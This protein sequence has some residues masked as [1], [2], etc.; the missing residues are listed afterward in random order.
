MR[1]GKLSRRAALAGGGATLLLPGLGW[2]QSTDREM[3]GGIGG[4]GIVGVLTDFG[5]L[6]VGGQYV[7]TD[8]GTRYTDGFGALQK[9]NLR[10]GDS[11]TVEASGPQSDLVARRVHVTHPLVGRIASG[12]GQ[13]FVV[14]GVSVTLNGSNG[15]FAVG[16]RV[17]VAGLWRG[18]R[19]I[20][21]GLSP[22]RSNLDLVSGDVIRG[23]NGRQ[24]GGI[25][26]RGGGL[27]RARIGSFVT[28]IGQF[29]Q[30]RP[31]FN[32]QRVR[33]ERFTGAAGPL[34]RLAVE[35]YLEQSSDAPGYRVSGL[36]HSFERNLQLAQYVNE[37]VLF[38]GGYTGR[39]AA[40]SAVILPESFAAR[41]RILRD[42][43]R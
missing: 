39:F 10:I 17:A 19:V 14:N 28:A 33:I 20:A 42:L 25:A 21:S 16:D 26:T 41:R 36:G 7:G 43:S 15:G 30:D 5:S 12:S 29:D 37:R 24:I 8:A 40:N 3:E 22:A 35:G 38:T 34:E 32:A 2:A 6:I 31:R 11:L 23:P 1:T 4:T 27:H 13:T 18:T 9:S